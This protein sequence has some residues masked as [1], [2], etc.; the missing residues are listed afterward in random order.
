MENEISGEAQFKVNSALFSDG[1]CSHLSEAEIKNID[2][3]LMFYGDKTAQWLS[4]LSHQE[5][6]WLDVRGD[7]P[8]GTVSENIIP[9]SAIHEYYSS[10]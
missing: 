6:P 2:K 8:P 7:L 3:V 4:T 10:L 1:D 9:K 5:N